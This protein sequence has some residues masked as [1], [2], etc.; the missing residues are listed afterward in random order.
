MAG[1][2]VRSG[3]RVGAR[4]GGSASGRAAAGS[5]RRRSI[6]SYSGWRR[7][8]GNSTLARGSGR[9][10][11]P[12]DIRKADAARRTRATTS[13]MRLRMGSVVLSLEAPDGQRE[14]G[15]REDGEAGEERSEDACVERGGAGD[16]RRG[17]GER[18]H[19]RQEQRDG[20]EDLAADAGLEEGEERL[21]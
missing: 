15:Q 4:S 9:G 20:A 16:R 13:Q 6:R 11:S 18:R 19:A 17:V 1:R 14:H 10:S 8:R 12:R 2:A 7:W 3:S 21:A 5:V